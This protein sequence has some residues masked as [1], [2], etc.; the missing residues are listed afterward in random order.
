MNLSASFLS[1]NQVNICVTEDQRRCSVEAL[2]G[3]LL[4]KSVFAPLKSV[5]VNKGFVWW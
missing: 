5:W 1:A 4:I 3:V 2:K